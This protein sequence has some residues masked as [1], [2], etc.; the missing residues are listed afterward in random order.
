MHH[1]LL[2]CI[3]LR[4]R[5]GGH[6][7]RT[8]TIDDIQATT[9]ESVITQGRVGQKSPRSFDVLKPGGSVGVRGVCHEENNRDNTGLEKEIPVNI[10]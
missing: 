5:S 7:R 10:S 6:D 8:E 1:E 3:L 4:T 9:S 2:L